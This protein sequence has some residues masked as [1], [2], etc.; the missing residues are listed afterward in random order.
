VDMTL[1]RV[2]SSVLAALGVGALLTFFSAGTAHADCQGGGGG[3]WPGG[4]GYTDCN[5]APD[6]SHDHCVHVQVLGFGGWQ[7]T[8]LRGNAP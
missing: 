3:G 7:C 4:G 5:Y 2:C 1:L 6:G 8:R